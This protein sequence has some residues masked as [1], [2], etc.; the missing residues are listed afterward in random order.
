MFT[1]YIL[2]SLQKDCKLPFLPEELT[3]LPNECYKGNYTDT[4][5]RS[6]LIIGGLLHAYETFRKKSL[7]ERQFIITELERGINNEAIELCSELK[8]PDVVNDPKYNIVYWQAAFH[9]T[10]NIDIDLVRDSGFI[11]KILNGTVKCVDVAKVSFIEMHPN[12]HKAVLEYLQTAKS[13]H[14]H[15]R[16]ST[17]YKCRKCG[18]SKCEIRHIINRALDEGGNLE[19]TCANCRFKWQA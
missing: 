17:M 3:P 10:G 2:M 11:D 19:V 16:T 14:I 13:S 5:R 18:E 8:V 15:Q 1:H 7:E 9:I 6:V 4:R 12:K